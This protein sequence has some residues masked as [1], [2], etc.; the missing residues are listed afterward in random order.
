MKWYEK[1]E[2]FY[3]EA[4][5]ELK[6]KLNGKYN[7][8]H[9]LVLWGVNEMEQD[10]YPAEETENGIYLIIRVYEENGNPVLI[11][12]NAYDETD[13]EHLKT[14]SLK[15]LCEVLDRIEELNL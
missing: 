1:F 10:S 7:H 2:K 6:K 9:H 13:V 8:K 5:T 3:E 4:F 14:Y 12:V 15:T 11:G